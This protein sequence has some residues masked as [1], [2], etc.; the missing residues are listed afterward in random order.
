MNC[1]IPVA[2][3]TETLIKNYN[4][5]T[6][7]KEY[8]LAYDLF[9]KEFKHH[10]FLDK[11]HLDKAVCYIRCYLKALEISGKNLS[12]TA[13]QSVRWNHVLSIK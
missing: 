4:E 9:V 3:R 5:R 1:L 13:L 8:D 12:I 10:D 2:K 6:D 11:R 7:T